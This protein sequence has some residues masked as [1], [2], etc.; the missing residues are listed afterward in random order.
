MSAYI[1]W[2]VDTEVMFDDEGNE[3]SGKEYALIAGIYVPAAERGRGI[4][5]KMLRDTIAEI[6]AKHPDMMIGLAA[7]PFDDCPMDMCELVEYYERF[8]FTV[9]N[10]DGAA[11]IMEM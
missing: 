4:G 1:S 2:S 8:G 7:L 11:V 6:K 10:T 9:T 3:S 5:S